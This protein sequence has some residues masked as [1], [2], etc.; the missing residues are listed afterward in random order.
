[1]KQIFRSKLCSEDSVT[2]WCSWRILTKSSVSLSVY[3]CC[4][5]PLLSH[6]EPRHFTCPE[7]RCYLMPENCLLRV[8]G[9]G[10]TWGEEEGAPAWYWRRRSYLTNK[11]DILLGGCGGDNFKVR[12]ITRV[13]RLASLAGPA[14]PLIRQKEGHV[15]SSALRRRSDRGKN[16]YS[17]RC[18]IQ[19]P[20]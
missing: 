16:A 2:H 10:K 1:M 14:A 4:F 6:R 13:S 18:K 8:I 15:H 20:I 9:N 12:A 17:C 5:I 3:W 11:P 19:L 7:T